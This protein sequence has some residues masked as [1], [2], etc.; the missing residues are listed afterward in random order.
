VLA[1]LTLLAA[2][3][4]QAESDFEAGLPEVEARL[5]A[6]E[7]EEARDQLKRLVGLAAGDP[8]VLPV[9][10]AVE[11][12]LVRIE[13]ADRLQ[14]PE[15]AQVVEGEIVAWRAS[16]GAIELRYTPRTLGDFELFEGTHVH[17]AT[18]D[19]PYSIEVRGQRFP[20]VRGS[21]EPALYLDMR[22]DHFLQ[23]ELGRID[24]LRRASR[25]G[26][27]ELDDSFPSAFVP[28]QPYE[29]RIKVGDST[30]AVHAGKKK[31]LSARRGKAEGG[32]FGFEHLEHFD[33]LILKGRVEPGW[34]R[35]G[36]DAVLEER[37]ARL[38][39]SLDF[40][41]ELGAWLPLPEAGS[42]EDEPSNLGPSEE[43]QAEEA[44]LIARV[45]RYLEDDRAKRALSY[46]DDKVAP[47]SV[48]PSLLHGLT[49]MACEALGD[50]DRAAAEWLEA[51]QNDPDWLRARASRAVALVVAGRRVD[52]LAELRELVAVDPGG[53]P[54]WPPLVRLQLELG[55]PDEAR[56]SLR[57]AAVTGAYS[58]EL[59]ELNRLMTTA[60]RGPD[61]PEAFEVRS[62]HYVVRSDIDKRLC[63]LAAD[64]LE[65]SLERFS[66]RLG[67]V[68]DFAGEPF[69][70]YLFAGE[71]GYRRY[72]AGILGTEPENTAGL[73]SP[74]T[75][76]LLIWNVP[77]REQ[78]MQTIRHEGL[79][80][81]LDRM[82][83]D[84][85]IWLN[86]GL[87]EYYETA[88]FTKGS[89]RQI[90]VNLHHLVVAR[91]QP[92]R[93]MG[94]FLAQNRASFY[95]NRERGYAHGWGFVHFLQN[96]GAGE[97]EV[98]DRLITALRSGA[99]SGEALELAFEGVDLADL[100]TRYFEYVRDLEP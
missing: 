39:A 27:E 6:R 41:R 17:P 8:E 14:L 70:V 57:E 24:R 32:R 5:D 26:L 82:A 38:L 69:E 22:D 99:S 35:A 21:D 96:G 92:I 90:E 55:R 54:A 34:I 49:A 51:K 60:R 2:P 72:S 89:S 71:A 73:Y 64:V 47:D 66:S 59:H 58:K 79:H 30:V 67:E 81:F 97:R 36:Q 37:R 80:Q 18:L 3:L 25:D 20:R 93:D 48:A 23:L 61:W 44:V 56:A 77:D 16:T 86:E 62:A 43:R 46:L 13:L 53:R 98:F 45:R 95:S 76:Q 68:E 28:E 11:Q 88:D 94:A 1:L 10:P 33:E 75:R 84:V 31:L 52:A 12:L 83:S 78:M 50:W 42:Y 100:G 65:S 4:A 19:G 7:W 63:S 29:L 40:E 87:A 85:P 15:P 9:L 91:R 74:V